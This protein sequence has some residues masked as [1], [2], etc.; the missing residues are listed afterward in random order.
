MNQPYEF[1]TE[2]NL[3]DYLRSNE[4]TWPHIDADTIAEVREIGDGNLNLVFHVQDA[5]DRGIIVKQALPYVRMVGDGWPM[6]PERAAREAHSLQVHNELVPDLVVKPI[7]YDPDRYILVLED[8]SDHA[9]WRDALNRGERHDGVAEAV[10][11]YVAAVASDTS[12]LGRDRSEV[13]AAIA[14]TQN[15]DLCVIT[16]DLVFTEPSFDVGRNVVLEANLPDAAA[17]AA[18]EVYRA[19]MAEAKRRFM[20]Q[21]ESLVHGDLHTGSIM[22]RAAAGSTEVDSVKVFD[23]E[24][25][26]YGPI[27]FDIGALFANYSFA[28][29]RAF[30]L[31]EPDRAQWALDLVAR[32]WNAFEQEFR[33]RAAGW[34]DTRLW[35]EQF[36]DRHLAHLMRESWLFV[37]AEMARR[38]VGAAKVRDIETL[39]PELREGAARA[40]LLAARAVAAAW[41]EPHAPEDFAASVLPV[42][43]GDAR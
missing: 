3:A 10:G 43:R 36:V 25:A 5:E 38:I 33:A 8:L 1:L 17:L 7:S 31:G 14:S 26:F 15:P 19:A 20:T 9:V 32:T 16:E 41:D 13:S 40:V 21:A 22:V 12:V 18:D 34:P 29:A 23:S 2:S 42:L 37:A 35:N 24:F 30:A 39:E 4:V 28:A 6:T 11:R 27:A